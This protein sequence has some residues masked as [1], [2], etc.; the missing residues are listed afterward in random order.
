MKTPLTGIPTVRAP[1][2]GIPRRQAPVPQQYEPLHLDMTPIYDDEGP[3]D[4]AAQENGLDEEELFEASSSPRH[5][6]NLYSNNNY[7]NN[8]NNNFI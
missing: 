7:N 2:T 5:V 8:N 1:H 6:I 3:V 4:L